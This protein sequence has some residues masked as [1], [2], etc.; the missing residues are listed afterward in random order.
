VDCSESSTS[1]SLS[2]Q[3]GLFWISGAGQTAPTL[4]CVHHGIATLPHAL[5]LLAGFVIVA[6]PIFTSFRL[7]SSCPGVR[8]RIEPSRHTG[9][10]VPTIQ[11]QQARDLDL[12]LPGTSD[13]LHFRVDPALTFPFSWCRHRQVTDMRWCVD[14]A[15]ASLHWR[16]RP[17][18]QGLLPS[19]GGQRFRRNDVQLRWR[20]RNRRS[21]TG[22]TRRRSRHPASISAESESI[23][24]DLSHPVDVASSI[25][26]GAGRTRAG[27]FVVF[28]SGRPSGGDD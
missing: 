24:D 14:R 4:T 23:L 25:V 5:Q 18:A 17:D 7:G 16:R 2:Q 12:L 15:F 19:T 13:L 22:L 28:E 20:A 10:E 8:G 1:S 27:L 9:S 21:G 11:D 26:R 3:H 6:A